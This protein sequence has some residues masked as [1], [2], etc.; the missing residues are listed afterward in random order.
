MAI[1][2]KSILE[3][4]GYARRISVNAR[5]SKVSV[6][7]IRYQ[8]VPDP[9]CSG[10]VSL[11]A[12]YTARRGVFLGNSRGE[13]AVNGSP[14]EI[15]PLLLTCGNNIVVVYMQTSMY[16]IDKRCLTSGYRKYRGRSPMNLCGT[17]ECISDNASKAWFI[18]LVAKA[19]V[20]A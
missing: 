14:G 16:V 20:Y 10:S 17:V 8:T 7:V 3:T 9:P 13:K 15:L 18:W 2:R 6:E 4:D 1:K 5:C 11:S 19:T 12:Q